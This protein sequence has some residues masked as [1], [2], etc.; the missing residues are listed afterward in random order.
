MRLDVT[1]I[2]SLWNLTRICCCQGSCQISGR[3][4]MSNPESRGFETSRDLAVWRPSAYQWKG[5]NNELFD[6]SGWLVDGHHL[7]HLTPYNFRHP[8]PWSCV[9]YIFYFV[10]DYVQGRWASVRSAVPGFELPGTLS[11]GDAM[12]I[13]LTNSVHSTGRIHACTTS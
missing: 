11:F 7:A 1:M 3:M 13:M 9:L 4:E 5:L 10:S 8:W 6:I 2:G 12:G